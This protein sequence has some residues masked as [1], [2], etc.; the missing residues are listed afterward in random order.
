[1]FIWTECIQ[2]CDSYCPPS[3]PSAPAVKSSVGAIHAPLC[4]L[5]HISTCQLSPLIV[6]LWEAVKTKEYVETVWQAKKWQRPWGY[7]PQLSNDP[8][9]FVPIWYTN[10]DVFFCF[11]LVCWSLK[12]VSDKWQVAFFSLKYIYRLCFRAETILFWQFV[13]DPIYVTIY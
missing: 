9:Y 3:H 12:F 1:M 7:C 8:M 13:A 2:W 11:W 6:L 10:S 5:F 4:S